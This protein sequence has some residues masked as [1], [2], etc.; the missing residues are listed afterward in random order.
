MTKN[1]SANAGNA[2]LIPDWEDPLKEKMATHS[3]I[4]AKI[5]PWAEKPGGLHSMESQRVRHD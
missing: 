3:R 5:I 2:G 1:P 4:L